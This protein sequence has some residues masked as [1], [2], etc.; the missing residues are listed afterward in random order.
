[1]EN[2]S[3]ALIMAGAVLIAM[4]IISLLVAFFGNLRNLQNTQLSKEQIEQAT[5][6]NKQYDVYDRNV[7]GSE[8]LSLA[9][10][11]KDYNK[12]QSEINDYTKIELEVTFL[13]DLDATL[14]QK[15]TYTSI[16]LI[17]KVENIKN[18]IKLVGGQSITFIKE[19]GVTTSK[20]ISQLATMRTIDIEE[21][22]TPQKD[23]ETQKNKYNTCKTL[24]TEIKTK[25]FKCNGFE[26][27]KNTGRVIKMSYKL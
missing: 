20:E 13:K 7:Y 17:E 1:M 14:L 22:G 18:E 8:L 12:R 15:G 11:I 19:G 4:I 25:V 10:K 6:F 26:Y 21:L 5:E 9:N 2:A 16:Q 23:Y 3:K 27:D 24:L